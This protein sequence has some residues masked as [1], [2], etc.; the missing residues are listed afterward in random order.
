MSF[1]F[2]H[3]FGG[4]GPQAAAPKAET[5]AA[6]PPEDQSE[7]VQ[8]Q[9]APPCGEPDQD[10]KPA[11]PPPAPSADREASFKSDAERAAYC[12]G[13]ADGAAAEKARG[14]AIASAPEARGRLNSALHLAFNTSLAA[15]DS[16]ALLATM[17]M[18]D[19]APSADGRIGLAGRMG[20][21]PPV[22]LGAGGSAAPDDRF[23]RMPTAAEVGGRR[24]AFAATTE[25]KGA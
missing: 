12:A 13:K 8:G 20:V 16:R 9:P 24:R 14:G 25:T 6:P 18:A 10:D 15:A 22:T 1:N 2:G 19:A 17:P 7:D 21:Q 11:D 3:L 5:T 23:K 4:Q